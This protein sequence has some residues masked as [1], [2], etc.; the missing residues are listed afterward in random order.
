MEQGPNSKSPEC[1]KS[2]LYII[3]EVLRLTAL[4]WLN[5]EF[6]IDVET[7]RRKEV[8]TSFQST[9]NTLLQ[10]SPPR[11]AQNNHSSASSESK[12]AQVQERNAYKDTICSTFVRT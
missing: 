4:L 10:V 1:F 2:A 11:F 3:S 7:K 5:A 12:L 6:V 8:E 9:K